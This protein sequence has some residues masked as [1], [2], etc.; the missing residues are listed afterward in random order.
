[1]TIPYIHSTIK[2]KNREMGLYTH[3]ADRM[4]LTLWNPIG[5]G[6]VGWIDVS[7]TA[8]QS[9]DIVHTMLHPPGVGPVEMGDGSF[10]DRQMWWVFKVKHGNGVHSGWLGV[11][12]DVECHCKLGLYDS[13]NMPPD[14][15]MA[16]YFFH[17]ATI[18][19][20]LKETHKLIGYI[21]HWAGAVLIGTKTKKV[22]R[23]VE[24]LPGVG[25]E[26]DNE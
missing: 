3:E 9:I 13:S 5:H 23:K 16:D 20:S 14:I 1:M 24:Y 12:T 4:G 7:F 22:S 8:K 18:S 11:T 17:S 21:M 15:G 10:E 19:L 2:F 6:R 26:A 25:L